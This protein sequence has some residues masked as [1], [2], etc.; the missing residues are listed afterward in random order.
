MPESSEG[1]T[2]LKQQTALLAD[3][4]KRALIQAADLQSIEAKLKDIIERHSEMLLPKSEDA[5]GLNR[6]GG[7]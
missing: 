6:C 5:S 4:A 1:D 2:A 3:L 7:Q